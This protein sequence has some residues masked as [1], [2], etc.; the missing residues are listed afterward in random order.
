MWYYGLDDQHSFSRHHRVTRHNLVPMAYA[1]ANN[2]LTNI[3]PPEIRQ[4]VLAFVDALMSD[5]ADTGNLKTPSFKA[6]EKFL[7]I[8]KD[9]GSFDLLWFSRAK[10]MAGKLMRKVATQLLPP[11]L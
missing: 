5:L 9:E 8:W 6:Q 10:V 2:F 7:K 11:E 4:F 1:M 3:C